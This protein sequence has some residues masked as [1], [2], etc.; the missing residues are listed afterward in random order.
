M[1]SHPIHNY[2]ASRNGLFVM[3][4]VMIVAG[5]GCYF[6]PSVAVRLLCISIGTWCGWLAQL[7]NWVRLKGNSEMLAEGQGKCL[8]SEPG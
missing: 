4:I 3:R 1:S 8:R 6:I 2:V 7:G 5:M